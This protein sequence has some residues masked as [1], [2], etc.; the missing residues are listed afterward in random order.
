MNSHNSA[1]EVNNHNNRKISA[2][3]CQVVLTALAGAACAGVFM[4]LLG[5]FVFGAAFESICVCNPELETVR[6]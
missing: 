4:G 6:L 2:S 5:A 3:H 1:P